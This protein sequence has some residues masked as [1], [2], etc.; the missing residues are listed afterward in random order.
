MTLG[1]CP[2]G[3]AVNATILYL[4]TAPGGRIQTATL[5]GIRRYAASLRCEVVDV[6]PADSRPANIATLLAAHRP[7]AGC[8]V[9]GSGDRRDLPPRVFGAVPVIYMHTEP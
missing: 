7:V 9:D 3:K 5:A 4:D 2:E 6:P 1:R 8:I